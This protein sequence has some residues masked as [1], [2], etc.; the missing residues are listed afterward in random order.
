M[1]YHWGLAVGHVYSHLRSEQ[2]DQAAR[3]SNDTDS[4]NIESPVQDNAAP[5][6]IDGVEE[7][8]AENIL[9]SRIRE[10]NLEYLVHWKGYSHEEDTWEPEDNVQNSADLIHQFHCECPSA[11]C[12]AECRIGESAESDGVDSADDDQSVSSKSQATD[13]LED[14]GDD[15]G[16]SIL[17]LHEMYGLSQ[18]C[19]VYE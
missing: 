2:Q 6:F 8:E 1:R 18:D 5:I 13:D 11:P 10:G 9:N 14:D 4:H 12:G 3:D 17:E 15:D 19:E 16:A 7:F